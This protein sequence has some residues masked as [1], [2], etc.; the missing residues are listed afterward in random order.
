VREAFTKVFT[1]GLK[2]RENG[3]LVEEEWIEI[4]RRLRE[5]VFPCPL[6]GRDV[7]LDTAALANSGSIGCWHPRCKGHNA[8]LNL[9]PRL[10][11]K[12]GSRERSI[13][14]N[15]NTRLLDYQLLPREY[16]LDKGDKI[17]GEMTQNPVDPTKWGIR[18]LSR[19][20]WQA[21]LPNGAIND[22]QPKKSFGLVNGLKIDFKTA[23]AEIIG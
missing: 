7:L 23:T 15:A 12:A 21:T 11:I 20:H 4:F 10:K 6:C 1:R 14:L 3:R 18:N 8:A 2:D 13:P 17:V 22:V 9:P 5:S 19:E 16:D